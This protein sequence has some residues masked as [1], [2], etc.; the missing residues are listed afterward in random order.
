MAPISWNKRG[1]FQVAGASLADVIEAFYPTIAWLCLRRDAF[2]RLINTKGFE[3][4][5]RLWEQAIEELLP[6]TRGG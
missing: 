4:V 3:K 5:F 6:G 2:E 1:A